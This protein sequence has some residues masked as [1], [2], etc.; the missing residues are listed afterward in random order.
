MTVG[1]NWKKKVQVNLNVDLESSLLSSS[2]AV[3]TGRQRGYYSLPFTASF[4]SIIHFGATIMYITGNIASL[5]V[6]DIIQSGLKC[7]VCVTKL[8]LWPDG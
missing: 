5:F 2:S 4:V 8:V 6:G 3:V 7:D 1:L